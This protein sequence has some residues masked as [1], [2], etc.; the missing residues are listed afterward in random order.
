M[1]RNNLKS[2]FKKYIDNFEMLNN[3][4]NDEIYKWE[5]AQE[6]QNFDVDAPDFAE[7]L[8]HMWKTT[9]NLIDSSQ[10]LPFYALVD[11][12]RKE[13]ETVREMFRKLYAEEHMDTE[14][15]Q[16][17]IDEFIASSEELRKKYNP[18]SRLYV[19]NQRSVMMYLFLRYPNSNFAYK[20]S[21]AKSFADCIEFY[22][23]WGP[24]TDFKLDIFYR[25]CEQLIEEIKT[26]D[27]LM[28]TH[29]SRFENTT[30]KLHPDENLHI[31]VFDIIFSSQA[32][33]F[34]DGMTYAPIN[35]QARKLYFEKVAKAKE[36][37]ET[38]NKAKEELVLLNEAKEYISKTLVPGM[39]VKHKT[40]GEGMIE[41]FAD[42]IL[43]V[44]FSK[45]NDTK[46]LGISV[47]FANG[48]I[49]LASDEQTQ[50]IKGYAPILSNE[51]K[52][53]TTISKTE[54]A[55]QEYLEFL[56]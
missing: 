53:K 51:S 31:L 40:F 4:K 19:N 33:N 45:I 55:L 30:R 9:D 22:D 21:Q 24:M 5:I 18:D 29:K 16:Q 28:E 43:S 14:A 15:K 56:E 1:N 41:E 35:A 46:K 11:Y 39:T 34:Y 7:M 10:Q 36:L 26:D 17:L 54:D 8:N 2:I 13:P 42:T 52:I 49:T 50:K 3:E 37:S 23:D 38:L 44:H 47:V 20:A 32:Y 27:A 25:M 12:A 6:F 48:L